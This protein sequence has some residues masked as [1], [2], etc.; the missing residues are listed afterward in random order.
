MTTSRLQYATSPYLQQHADNPVDWYPWSEEALQKAL[1]ENK[2]IL[3]SIGYFACHWCHVMAHESFADIKTAEIMNTHFINIKVDREERPDLDRIYQLSHQ[4]LTGRGGGW[5][6]TVFL[7]PQDLMPFFAGT[8]FPPEPHYGLPGFKEVL[9]K[10]STYFKTHAHEIN[11]QNAHLKTALSQIEFSASAPATLNTEPLSAAYQELAYNFDKINGGFGNAPKFPHPTNLEYLLRSKDPTEIAHFSLLKMAKGGIYDQLGGGFFRYSVDA[12]W[13]IPHFEKML[14]D[15]A[16]LLACYSQAGLLKPELHF[17]RVVAGTSTWLL[18]VM[19][20][21]EGGFYSALDADSEHVEGKYYYWDRNE[22][23]ALLTEEEYQLTASYYGLDRPPNF[24]HHWHLTIHKEIQLSENI[25]EKLLSTRKKR[26]RPERDE[27]ILTA[28]NALL[29]KGFVFAGQYLQRK[30]LIATA[31]RIVDFIRSNLW[32]ENKLYAC[33][34]NGQSYQTAYLDDYAF[35]LDALLYLLQQRWRT[36]DLQFTIELAE[37][38]IIN[39]YDEQAGGFFFTPHDY[40]TLIHRSKPFMDDVIPSG[41]GAATFALARLGYLLGETRYLQIVEKTLQAAWPVIKEHPSLHCTLL[42]ALDE[43]FDP[44]E[45]IVLRGESEALKATHNN[46]L[47]DYNPRR[48]VLAISNTE[49]NLPSALQTRVPTGTKVATYL[50]K[51]LQCKIVG[52]Q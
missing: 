9:L 25:Q 45:I 21:P 14:Y 31:Q 46:Y 34:R 39:F 15:N 5:P 51:G 24:E 17:T 38:L 7:T 42:N 2:P 35:L 47:K 16:Q 26:T 29:I 10:I 43:Y 20:A 41:N 32:Q 8:Y 50:C 1:Q 18:E 28:W 13:Q 12:Q 36:Q 30:D 52:I 3:L 19:Q 6:L 22:I 11:Q 48:L 23:K 40:E 27:K 33:Y 37:A 4:L 44:P 49:I